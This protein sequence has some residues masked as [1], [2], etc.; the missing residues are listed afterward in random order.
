VKPSVDI[1]R[2]TRLL[3]AVASMSRLYSD[4]TIPYVDSRFVEKLFIETSGAKDLSRSDKSFDALLAPDVGVGIK[5][6]LAASSNSKREKVAEFT[7][8]ANHGEFEGLTPENLALK[9]ASFRNG[10]ILSDANELAIDI[11]SSIYHCLVRITNGAVVHEEPYL[12]ID[13]Q[14]LRP[15]D[16][17]GKT[18]KKWQTI[19]K[20]VFFSDGISNYNFNGSK[21]VLFKEFKFKID[22][23]VIDL[24]VFSDIFDR[25]T[26]WFDGM[27]PKPIIVSDQSGNVLVAMDTP[28]YAR[29]GIDFVVL[30]LYSVQ[31]GSKE[32]A[33]KSG[34]NQWNAGGRQR[35]FGEAY[36]PIPSEVHRLCPGF[37]PGRDVKFDMYLPNSPSSVQAKVC[38]QGGKALMSDPNTVLGKWIMRVLRPGLSDADFS[39]FPS[40]T[41]KPFKYQE[42]DAIGKDSVIVKKRRDKSA[43]SYLVEFAGVGRYEEFI[44]DLSD[45]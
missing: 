11:N 36:I 42:L 5:T 12:P 38:Q 30:P 32:V 35:K 25:I 23:A 1:V 31:T 13:I 26:Q 9:V 29:P 15:T 20:G 34:I 4:N 40:N 24:P 44:N 43:T 28:D 19:G 37:F 2:Y 21:N 45:L 10:R 7:S 17:S 39:R 14:N 22:E 6:F 8:F 16:R 18:L 33:E 3:Q 41:D 27:Q